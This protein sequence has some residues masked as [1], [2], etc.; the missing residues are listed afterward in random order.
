[1]SEKPTGLVTLAEL[2]AAQERIRGIVVHT[3]LVAFEVAGEPLALWVKA[4][5]LQP[6]G[7]FKLR[8][9]YNKVAQLPPANALAV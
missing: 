9:A 6:I 1:M 5:G 2:R 8:G 3:P 4:E 7:S